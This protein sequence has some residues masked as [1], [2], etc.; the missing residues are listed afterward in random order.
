[1]IAKATVPP[2]LERRVASRERMIEIDEATI[3]SNGPGHLVRVCWNQWRTE[4][5]L[6][7]RGIH[8]RSTDPALVE[9]A[10]AAMTGPEFEAVNGRQDWANWRTMAR[11][12]SGLVPDRPLT[13]LDLGCGSGG[14]TR[15]LAHYAPLGSRITGY[16]VARPLVRMARQRTYHHHSGRPVH[17]DFC[18]LSMTETFRDCF[19]HPLPDQSVDLV[20]ASGVVGHHL[21]DEALAA[22]A[23]EL[24]RV[25]VADG[26]AM[27]DISP[28]RD[29]ERLSQV[30]RPFGFEA[31]RCCRSSVFDRTGQ[32]TLRRIRRK[33][34]L[35]SRGLEW[36]GGN[37]PLFGT[38]LTSASTRPARG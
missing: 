2:K 24:C 21:T 16:E 15:V 13:V 18:C 17:V 3:R 27:L 30:M 6:A 12:M 10:Y 23:G 7:R 11:S 8:I 34:P 38:A 20:N 5:Q 26:L 35:N 36:L 29:A 28:R 37:T 25:M 22:L 4:R 31:V 19:D 9:A 14:S 33:R 1:M 32:L